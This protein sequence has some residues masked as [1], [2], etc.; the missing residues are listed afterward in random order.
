[1]YILN[2]IKEIILSIINEILNYKSCSID[3]LQKR[4]IKDILKL[5]N[6]ERGKI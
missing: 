6:S 3:N 4:L 2:K 1:M 5:S